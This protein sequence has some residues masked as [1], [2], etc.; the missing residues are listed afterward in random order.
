MAVGDRDVAHIRADQV[1]L[2]PAH[3]HAGDAGVG[4]H[5]VS[6]AQ[7]VVAANG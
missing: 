5:R 2:V 1:G 7:G 4:L 6:R 3:Q